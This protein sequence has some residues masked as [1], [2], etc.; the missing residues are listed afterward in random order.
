MESRIY[1]THDSIYAKNRIQI[2]KIEQTGVIRV[3]RRYGIEPIYCLIE[4][5]L[6]GLTFMVGHEVYF[7]PNTESD[8]VFI[9]KNSFLVDSDV[10]EIND[11]L[12]HAISNTFYGSS[13]TFDRAIEEFPLSGYFDF[14]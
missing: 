10:F 9:I 2:A 4:E 3:L 11:T 7:E 8:P 5:E 6:I 13:E 1:F 14:E 12:N